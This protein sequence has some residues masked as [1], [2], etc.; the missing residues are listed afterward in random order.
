[1]KKRMK[2]NVL[3]YLFF[4][5]LII[6]SSC[7]SNESD[8]GYIS[9]AKRRNQKEVE[10]L[11]N[12]ASTVYTVPSMDHVKVKLNDQYDE[13]KYM[14]IYYPPGFDFTEKLPAM[15][16]FN[17]FAGMQA[18]NMG[19]H[20][21]WASLIAAHGMIGVTYDPVYPDKDLGI[22]LN[23]LIQHS[24]SLGIDSSRLGLLC[25]CGTCPDGLRAFRGTESE[26]S[27]SLNTGVFLYGTMP[28]DDSIRRDASILMVKTG[29]GLEANIKK[30]I[31]SF[32]YKAEK[33]GMN[34]QVINHESGYKYFDVT[35][36]P[37]KPWEYGVN[38]AFTA[39]CDVMKDILSWM[40][41]NMLHNAG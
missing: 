5:I 29:K 20:I 41:Q 25:Y 30:S 4:C 35:E 8:N 23:N 19:R 17:G 21:D 14:D 31:D 27:G 24:N 7:R 36:M 6:F 1:M 34:V 11:S 38:Q 32:A 3:C 16:I 37:H 26:F 13:N 22:L 18:K 2:L 33:A 40:Q 15:I 28:W 39:D 10:M 9:G 12:I